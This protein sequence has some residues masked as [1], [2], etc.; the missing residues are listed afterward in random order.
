MNRT[1]SSASNV[2]ADPRSVQGVKVRVTLLALAFAE[3]NRHGH[4]R[5]SGYACGEKRDSPFDAVVAKNAD[6]FLR[7]AEIL[8]DPRN[9]GNEFGP[10]QRTVPVAHCDLRSGDGSVMHEGLGKLRHV[11]TQKRLEQTLLASARRA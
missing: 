3:E 1:S 7:R 2:A 9:P 8:C 10:R 5:L 11:R 4:N 6:G